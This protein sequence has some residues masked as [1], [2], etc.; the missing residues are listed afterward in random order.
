MN[1]ARVFFREF[2]NAQAQD[3]RSVRLGAVFQG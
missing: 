3:L 2:E 1:E